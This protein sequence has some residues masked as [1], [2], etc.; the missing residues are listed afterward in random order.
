MPRYSFT[1]DM[2]EISGFGGGYEQTCRN[3]LIAAVERLDAH[4]E[5]D[6]QFHGFK[7]IYGVIQEDNEDA[8]ALSKIVVGAS[9][10]DCTGAMHQAVISSALYIKKNG[11]EKYKAE[12]THPEGEVGLLKEKIKRLE[13][14]LQRSRD[15]RD[16]QEEALRH[17]GEI[18]A[19][20]VLG[21][22]KYKVSNGQ[23]EAYGPSQEA[24]LEDL[25][26]GFQ[27]SHLIDEAIKEMK[28][29]A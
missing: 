6:P 5:A 20:K 17:R 13:D 22:K 2:G 24:V 9:G 14:D 7:G 3:M 25:G 23:Q 12:M 10:G 18:I 4:P 21:W 27:L 19:E 16:K 8:K 28:I 15:R 29:A 11:W 1:P 26:P